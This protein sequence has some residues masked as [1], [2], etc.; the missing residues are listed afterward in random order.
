MFKSHL[1][2]SPQS[3]EQTAIFVENIF[4]TVKKAK[5]AKAAAKSLADTKPLPYDDYSFGDLSPVKKK[6]PRKNASKKSVKVKKPTTP[7]RKTPLRKPRT[8]PKDSS[9]KRKK[10]PAK[11]PRKYT[12]RVNKVPTTAD[13]IDDEEAAFILSSISQRSFDSF[14][15]RLNSCESGKFQIPI[16]LSPT[17]LY[18]A[19]PDDPIK[20]KA[21]YVM[22]DHN[23]W[24]AQPEAQPLKEPEKIETIVVDNSPS[25][26]AVIA[27]EIEPEVK[28]CFTSQHNEVQPVKCEKLELKFTEPVSTKIN[29]VVE[30]A[31]TTEVNNNK[32]PSSQEVTSVSPETLKTENTS[33]KKRW[34]RQAASDMNTPVKKRK[35]AILDNFDAECDETLMKRDEVAVSK[36][37]AGDNAI[38]A[39]AA[40]SDFVKIE[41]KVVKYDVE[42]VAPN[43]NSVKVDKKAVACEIKVENGFYDK[44]FSA[45]SK[46]AQSQSELVKEKLEVKLKVD[47]TSELEIKVEETASSE[48]V[49]NGHASVFIDTL[50]T[51]SPDEN[52]KAEVKV[53]KVE[54]PATEVIKEPAKVK[55]RPPSSLKIEN[56]SAT[57]AVVNGNTNPEFANELGDLIANKSEFSV[58]EKVKTEEKKLDEEKLKILKHE[59]V[60]QPDVEPLQVRTS[61]QESLVNSTD[62]ANEVENPANENL[63]SE[64]DT[65]Q[66]E[67]VLDFHRSQLMQLELS[68]KR[69]TEAKKAELTSDHFVSNNF[70]HSNIVNPIRLPAIPSRFSLFPQNE[71]DD[72]RKSFRT[73]LSIETNRFAPTSS[74]FH[75]SISENSFT[76]KNRWSNNNSSTAVPFSSHPTQPFGSLYPESSQI[77]R[78]EPNATSYNSYRTQ[79]GPWIANHTESSWDAPKEFHP[80]TFR[81][82][83]FLNYANINENTSLLNFKADE[84][85]CAIQKK[86]LTTNL[87]PTKPKASVCDPRLNPSLQQEGRKEEAATPKKKVRLW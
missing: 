6:K 40:V 10:T 28:V 33:V 5:A 11:S 86:C 20:N 51:S 25:N 17:H 64:D 36:I 43:V 80:S 66:W 77:K 79:R 9:E 84:Q 57:I 26:S 35:T 21:Y 46:K 8:S 81:T 45:R 30:D 42:A 27:H 72:P 50:L 31:K 12:K 78:D 39:V 60:D 70:D 61:E 4:D 2:P 62:N 59:F 13:S 82:E 71:F 75:R 24:V 63:D 41:D 37:V 38:L 19:P 85:I 3:F 55:E 76:K 68:N 15:N 23:Y 52:L 18:G 65:K 73:S 48:P 74:T 49:Q 1:D 83:S 16:E 7:K 29:S 58:D 47:E 67:I 53:L 22:L 69:F 87:Q 34:L 32:F 56:D 14:Y 44:K 54:A